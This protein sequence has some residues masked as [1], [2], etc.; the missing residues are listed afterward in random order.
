MFVGETHRARHYLARVHAIERVLIEH[1]A[2]IESMSPQDFLEFRSNLSPASGFQSVQF[3][4][5]EFLSGLKHRGLASHLGEGHEERERLERRLREP[6]LWD[7]F[8][9]FLTAEALPMPE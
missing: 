7:A 5:V 1:I 2:V 4:E 6:S 3:R 8:C 9:D